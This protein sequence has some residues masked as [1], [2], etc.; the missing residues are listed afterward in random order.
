[1]LSLKIK[2]YLNV[3]NFLKFLPKIHFVMPLFLLSVKVK[4]TFILFFLNEF[5]YRFKYSIT[6]IL[7]ITKITP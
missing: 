1:M 6:K 2:L 7:L 3:F 5:S 4:Y